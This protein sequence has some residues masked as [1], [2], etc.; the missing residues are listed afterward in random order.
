VIH[1]YPTIQWL[2]SL[3]PKQFRKAY[4]RDTA[5]NRAHLMKL[6]KAGFV[7]DP[8]WCNNQSPNGTCLG[9]EKKGDEQ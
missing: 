7:W 2:L 9:H 1:C 8:Q 5:G 4:P 6:D 3:P